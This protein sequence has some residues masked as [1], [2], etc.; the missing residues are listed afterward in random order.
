MEEQ[1]HRSVA[2]ASLAVEDGKAIDAYG[3]VGNWVMHAAYI[4]LTL[5]MA[6]ATACFL[7][8]VAPDT[9]ADRPM[10]VF[11]GVLRSRNSD[12]NTRFG[13]LL[14]HRHQPTGGRTRGMGILSRDQSGRR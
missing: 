10:P 11:T 14:H 6:C 12:D 4:L 1:K 8:K 5:R 9:A 13:L 2:V 7:R 3:A